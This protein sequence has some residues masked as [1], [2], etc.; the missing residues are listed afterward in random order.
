MRRFTPITLVAASLCLAGP[1][2]AQSRPKPPAPKPAPAYVFPK[3][4]TQTLP[5]GLVVHIIENHALPLVA[6][7]AVIEGGVLLDPAGKEG[8]FTLDTLLLR[9]GTT[10]LSGDALADAI[11]EL[12]ASVSP[13]GFTT[14]TEQLE[15]SL[16]L[17]SD[18]LMH[19]TFPSEA[20]DRRRA[21][22]LS[23]IQRAEGQATTPANRIFNVV[24]FGADHPL[25]RFVTPAS[26]ASISTD[27]LAHFHAEH[28]RPQNVTLVM[29]GDI[30][31]ASAMALAT[32]M[33]GGWQRS[34]DRAVVNAPAAPSPKPTTIYLLD[35]PGAPQ[36][37]IYLGQAGPPRS[38]PDACALDVASFL[39][40]GQSGSRLWTQLR[41][42]RPLTYGITHV[43]RWRGAN[44]PSSILGQSNVDAT[45]TDSALM[46]W[47][48]EL[49]D[50]AS[51]RAPT[52]QE[53]AFGRSVTAGNLA[54][55]LETFDAVADRAAQM[56]R[57]H[58]PMTYLEGYV[59]GINAATPS[60]VGRAAARY[61]DPAHTAIVVVG[62]RKTIEAPLREANV[63]PVVIVDA[64]GKVAP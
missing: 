2:A 14:V 62:D 42:R 5:N 7:R 39:F 49:K 4:Q 30:V 10:T 8:L 28:V 15:R 19:P 54:T 53:V 17:M 23:L 33:F 59:R 52:D 37:T 55:R 50:L 60:D 51:G 26:L 45:K 35:R 29:V 40:G 22:L 20:L 47:I 3:V 48:G 41:D 12:G 36:S 46:V 6:V 64:N 56:A 61:F 21:A 44:D 57:E 1:A 11:G 63:A 34:G 27:D 38:A 43:T 25:G 32:R 9:D 24:V 58:V 18:M 16:A 13:S 31:P